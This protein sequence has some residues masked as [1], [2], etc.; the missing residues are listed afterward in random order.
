MRLDVS[1]FQRLRPALLGMLACLALGACSRG[2]TDLEAWVAEVKTR[3][4]PALDALPV[5]R[6]FESFQYAAH[7]LRDPFS[8]PVAEQTAA[9]QGPRPDPN[10]RKELLEG[11]PLDSL[12]MVGTLTSGVAQWA[13]IMAPDKVVHRI[14]EGNYMG[15]NEG[16]VL[17]VGDN[18]VELLELVSDGAGGWIERP[19]T[20][21]LEDR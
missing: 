21:A 14:K 5:M 4:A 20:I 9:A 12:A 15:Q 17:A 11:F 18:G 8:A 7:D 10:R 1:P 3:P 6:Q 2:S 19:A 13:L 16:R